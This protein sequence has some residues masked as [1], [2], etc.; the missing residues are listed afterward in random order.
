MFEKEI[1][2]A[3]SRNTDRIRFRYGICLND[4]CEKCKS[5]EVQEIPAR[6]EFVCSECGKPLRECPPPKKGVNKKLIGIIF[7]VVALAIVGAVL[8]LGGSGDK[9]APSQQE[10]AVAPV[11]SDSIKAAQL[12]ME[13]QRVQDSLQAVADSLAALAA[14]QPKAQAEAPVATPAPRPTS[15]SGTKDLGYATFK[16]SW[17]DDVNGRLVFKTDHQID[18]RDSKARMA[19]AGDYVIGEFSEGHLVQGIWYG[20]DGVVKGSIIIGK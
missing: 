7:G 2:M 17:P 5:K 9:A 6:K 15:T 4:N 19:E 8:L 16:G 12:A 10:A 20:A 14:N 18:S 3:S 11:D 1:N 13:Q